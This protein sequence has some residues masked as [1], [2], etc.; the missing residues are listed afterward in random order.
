MKS[1]RLIVCKEWH[2]VV[3]PWE[4]LSIMCSKESDQFVKIHLLL[5]TVDCSC[6]TTKWDGL[7]VI[8]AI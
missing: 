7:N 5:Q 6:V 1:L 4:Q 3:R 2:V 8:T